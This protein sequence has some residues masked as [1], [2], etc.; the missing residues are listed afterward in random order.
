MGS[1]GEI[2]NGT[3][4]LRDGRVVALG[5]ARNAR[6]PAGA[7]VIDGTGQVVTPGFVA[8]DTTLTLAKWICS[9]RHARRRHRGQ[10]RQS[11][12]FDVATASTS[13]RRNPAGAPTGVTRAVVTPGYG[14][15]DGDA[16][17]LLFAGQA[18]S[19]AWAAPA[20]RC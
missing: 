18:A 9:Q 17:E 16:P 6:S 15:R 5:S 20:T 8:G 19:C 10:R 7:R 1:A 4:V 2:A 12:A 14:E 11:A 3:L 13:T